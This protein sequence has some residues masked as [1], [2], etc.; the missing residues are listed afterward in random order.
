MKDDFVAVFDA[1][2]D[3][4]SIFQ[5]LFL[6]LFA[7]HE[8]AIPVA[9]V[10]EPVAVFSGHNRRASARDPAVGKLQVVIAGAAAANEKR[11]ECKWNLLA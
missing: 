8:E 4:I 6:Y 1:E 2:A 5:E 9:T 3:V 7:V 10:F 11:G